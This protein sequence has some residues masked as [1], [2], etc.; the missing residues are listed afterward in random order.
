M[1][2]LVILLCMASAALAQ[3]RKKQEPPATDRSVLGKTKSEQPVD[4]TIKSGTELGYDDNFLDLNNKQIKQLEDGTKPEKFRIDEAD[5]FVYSVWAEIKVK[6]KLLGESSQAVFKVQPKFYQ[7]NS[8]A[9]YAE[10]ELHLRRDIGRH[11]AGLEYRFD[12]DV[13]LR[14]LEHT[15]TD[16]NSITT[17]SWESARYNEHDLEAYYSHQALDWISV[18]G[19]AGWRFKDFDAPFNFRDLDGFFIAVGP[20]VRLGKGISAFLR[21]EFSDMTSEAS[22]VEPDTSYRQH[23]VEIGGAIELMKVVEISLKYRVGL[24]DYT[25]SNDPAVDPSHADRDDVRH[26]VAFR[27][28]WKISDQWS[29]RLEYVYRQDDS[30][31]PFDNN[32]TT[33]EPGDST[34]NVVS[35]GATFAF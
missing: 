3:Q 13:Y 11:E 5:D 29:V 32:S 27:V 2:T 9:N 20:T 22:S 7:S 18:R 12:H 33:N 30:H 14:E 24:R 21:Y 17:T 26:K 1:R 19:S 15:F 23:E 4:V 6:G 31:R 25:T 10:Y 28:R 34:R 35:I 8:I 16:S